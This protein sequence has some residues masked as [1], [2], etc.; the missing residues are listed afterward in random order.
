MSPG[1]GKSPSQYYPDFNES[2]VLNDT[3]GDEDAWPQLKSGYVG[4][5]GGDGS[6][7]ETAVDRR[8][9][10]KSEFCRLG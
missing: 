4:G 8:G 5:A 2:A 3:F 1:C 6:A 9:T 10:Q 7:T